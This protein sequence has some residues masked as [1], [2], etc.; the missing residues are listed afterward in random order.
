M[1]REHDVLVDLVGDDPRVELLGQAGDQFELVAREDL[2]AGVRGIAEHQGFR[3]QRERAPQFVRVEGEVGRAQLDV[4]RFGPAQDGVGAVV[5]VERREDDHPVAR[6][7]NGHHR[8]H[9]G[10]GAATRDD[11]IGVGVQRQ[12]HV[13]ALFRGQCLP[14]VRRTPGDRVLMRAFQGRAC[15][16]LAECERRVEVREPLREIDAPVLVADARHPPDDRV[17]EMLQAAAELRHRQ[18]PLREGLRRRSV[19][20]AG[21]RQQAP[22]TLRASD[23]A[24]TP[25]RPT[26][27]RVSRPDANGPRVRARAAGRIRP[28]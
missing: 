27:G 21:Y 25:A 15:R 26:R 6:L 3:P 1:G 20:G 13:V 23:V 10:F 16:G 8:R 9:H 28:R 11:H 7:A 18:A 5:L 17:G 14:E 4:H 24:L 19:N 12:P 2:A 22:R